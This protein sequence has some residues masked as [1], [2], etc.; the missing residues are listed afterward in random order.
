MHSWWKVE[1]LKRSLFVYDTTELFLL[2]LTR[3]GAKY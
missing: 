1:R 3:N 2:A